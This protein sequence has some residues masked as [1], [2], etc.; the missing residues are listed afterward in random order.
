M[1]WNSNGMRSL[2][3]AAGGPRLERMQSS[4]LWA[5][6]G[7]RNIH[8][9]LAGLRDPG[10][11]P[12]SLSEFLCGGERRVPRKQLPSVNPRDVWPSAPSSGLRATWLGHSTVLIEIDGCRVLTDPVWGSRASPSRPKLSIAVR[13]YGVADGRP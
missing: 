6:E 5:G 1:R 7:F 8:P 3:K 10:V 11:R 4:P 12:P 2:G 13:A 9:A